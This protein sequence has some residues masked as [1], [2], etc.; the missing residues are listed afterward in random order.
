MGL[1]RRDKW[2]SMDIR[3]DGAAV[4]V[5]NDIPYEDDGICSI[6]SLYTYAE[7]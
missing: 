4:G 5:A 2:V 1:K 3:I 6:L 7:Y